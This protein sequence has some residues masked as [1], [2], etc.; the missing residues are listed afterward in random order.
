MKKI[1]L[2]AVLLI[3]LTFGAVAENGR[4]NMIAGG[5]NVS[6]IIFFAVF[7]SLA[8]E[9]ERM[10]DDNGRFSLG[11]EIGNTFIII[12]S[13]EVRGRWYP[14]SPVFFTG[15]GLG[16][17]G[18]IPTAWTPNYKL[19]M[20]SPQVAWR[21]DIGQPSGW[22]MLPTI[23]GRIPVTSFEGKLEAPGVVFTDIALKFGYQF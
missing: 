21:I 12:P 19:L 20:V 22:V 1:T 15:L 23:T 16:A 9:Y 17:W 8:L 14:R 11:A 7:P 13:A 10:L 18:F 4:K 2:C 6:G 3:A 5:T